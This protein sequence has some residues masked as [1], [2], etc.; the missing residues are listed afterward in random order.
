MEDDLVSDL[1]KLHV[2]SDLKTPPLTATEPSIRETGP[3]LQLRAAIQREGERLCR[4]SFETPS[5]TGIRTI[6]PFY[7]VHDVLLL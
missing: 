5:G 3:L 4:T 2:T 6:F 1:A 7:I